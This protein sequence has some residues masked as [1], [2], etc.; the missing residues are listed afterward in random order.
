MS[1]LGLLLWCAL[2][3]PGSR[4]MAISFPAD[5][6]VINVKTE[7]GAVGNGVADDTAALQA[8]FDAS[9]GVGGPTRVVFIPNGTY[10]LTNTLVAKFG[11]GPWVYGESRDG[12]VLRLDDGVTNSSV[13]SVLR[14]HPSDTTETS[15]D[16]FMR[17][18]RNF[19]VN[20]GNNPGIDGIRWYGNNSSIL[21][22][23]RVIGTGNV[24]INSGYLGQNGPNLIQDVVVEGF[25]TGIQAHWA[26]AR[27]YRERQFE[28][29]RCAVCPSSR[30]AWRSRIS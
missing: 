24:G 2:L 10:R 13:T 21:Q 26:G 29:A 22:N 25:Q 4:L 15:A 7:F 27:Q 16:Y 19:T 6:A 8:A 12:V 23:V 14:G 3:V 18:F 9:C 20:V 5:S 17:N 11:V 1:V 28:I 30:R